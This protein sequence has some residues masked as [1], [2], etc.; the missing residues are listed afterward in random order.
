M[1]TVIFHIVRLITAIAGVEYCSQLGRLS[2][3]CAGASYTWW[4]NA[5]VVVGIIRNLDN[6]R[7]C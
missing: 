7:V 2:G 3:G 4:V 1:E 6:L 5:P